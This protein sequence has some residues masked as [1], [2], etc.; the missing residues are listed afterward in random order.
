M[1]S[2]SPVELADQASRKRAIAVAI[3]AAVFLMIQF[4]TRP[5]PGSNPRLIMWAVNAAAL[6]PLLFTG[7]G[8]IQKR[9]IRALMNDDVSRANYKSAV[10]IGYWTAMIVAM[11]LY[12]FVGD[13][14][15][16]AREAIYFIVTPSVGFALLAFS[17]L[18]LRA[19]RDA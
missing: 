17:W 4:V 11:G 7:G 18:E 1:Q 16:T 14:G 10:G 12:A 6:L 3:A 8:L 15:V 2:K 5:L 9:E 13:S 19:H